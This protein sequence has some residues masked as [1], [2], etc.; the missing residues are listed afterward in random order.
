MTQ[1]DVFVS[2]A[3]D[4]KKRNPSS[5]RDLLR[6]G[7]ADPKRYSFHDQ[8]VNLPPDCPPGVYLGSLL[9]SYTEFLI[10]SLSNRVTDPLGKHPLSFATGRNVSISKK[11]SN[12]QIT[13]P[14]GS[15]TIRE[16]QFVADC[17]SILTQLFELNSRVHN[18]EGG[19]FDFDSD[20][21]NVVG[22]WDALWDHIAS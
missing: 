11:N 1:F 16:D 5:V 8:I 15:Y 4:S 20:P 17:L 9:P 14:E 7:D 12:L 13:W 2:S 21:Y 10:T 6:N 19:Q 3:C 18:F 22:A